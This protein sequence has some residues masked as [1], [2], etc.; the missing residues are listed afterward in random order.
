MVLEVISCTARNGRGVSRYGGR[1]G[2]LSGQP[3]GCPKGYEAAAPPAGT[4]VIQGLRAALRMEW[5][6]LQLSHHLLFPLRACI[7]LHLGC[8]MGN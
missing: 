5:G 4:G 7:Y 8:E 2:S 6:Q 1:P 3:G